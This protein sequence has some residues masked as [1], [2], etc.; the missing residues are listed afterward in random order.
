M[1]PAWTLPTTHHLTIGGVTFNMVKV[2][3]GRFNNLTFLFFHLHKCMQNVNFA[4][5]FR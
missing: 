2:K 4:A 3:G 5:D 1:L